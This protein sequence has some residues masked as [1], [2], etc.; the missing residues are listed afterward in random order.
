VS[1]PRLEA[2]R[3]IDGFHLDELIHD[4]GMAAIWRVSH[5]DIAMPMIMKVPL[6]RPGEDVLTIVGYEVESMILPRLSGI[7]V[8]RFVAA[9]GF[10]RPYIVMELVAGRS[11]ESRLDETPWPYDEVATI[12]GRI[13]TALQ[14]IH[15]QH[16][17]HLDVNPSN[18]IMRPTGEATLIDFG[19]ARHAEH[20]DLLAAE[21]YAPIGTGPYI[22]PEQVLQNRGDPRSDLFA[23]GVILYFLAL[24]AWPFGDPTRVSE[25]RRR[26]WR[27][28]DPPRRL[29]PDFPPWLQ[30]ILLRCLEVDPGARHATAAEL[31]YDLEHPQQVTL[32]PRAERTV[33]DRR[34]PV[35]TRSFRARNEPVAPPGGAGHPASPIVMVAIDV[36]P[37]QEA[38][39]AALRAAVRRILQTE[40]GARLACVNV[41]KVS[42]VRVDDLEDAEGRNLHLQRLAEL[43][44]WARPLSIEPDRVTYHVFESPDPAGALLAYARHNGVDHAVMGA[45]GSSTLRRY[46]GSVSSRVVAEA[47]CTVTVVRA[48]PDGPARPGVDGKSA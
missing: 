28:P 11:L 41:L 46:L 44:R 20:P 19:V 14:D 6:L 22:S 15:R 43:E 26:L 45:R 12:G 2:G 1:T 38:L 7:H 36:A 24:G 33:R 42:R 35:T 21:I 25:W 5:V 8:P 32:T 34:V 16:V 48:G 10:E 13:A 27:D 39:A 37:A 31:A 4:G 23:L 3:L 30:E 17:V 40:P 47:P 9:G 29:R 18:I